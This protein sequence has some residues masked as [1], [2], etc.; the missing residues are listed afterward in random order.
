M[1]ATIFVL[2]RSC[3]APLFAVGTAA[4]AANFLAYLNQR[5]S[6]DPYLIREPTA[7]EV[8][9]ITARELSLFDIGAAIGRLD[10]PQHSLN[11]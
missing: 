10:A 1:A 4:Q 2:A 11:L 6:L 7:D 8:A 5:S 9:L 3:A